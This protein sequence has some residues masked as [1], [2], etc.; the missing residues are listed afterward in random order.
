MKNNVNVLCSTVSL[1]KG[2]YTVSS[3]SVKELEDSFLY[4]FNSKE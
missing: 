4:L 3:Y 2:T 1:P